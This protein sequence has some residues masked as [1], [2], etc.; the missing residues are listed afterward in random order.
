MA[1]AP[2]ERL[3]PDIDECRTTEPAYAPRGKP[4]IYRSPGGEL[5]IPDAAMLQR[6]SKARV[7]DLGAFSE[8]NFGVYARICAPGSSIMSCDRT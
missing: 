5:R 1:V 7:F 6:L 8:R 4:F 3:M 2:P